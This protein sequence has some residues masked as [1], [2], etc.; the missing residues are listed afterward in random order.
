MVLQPKCWQEAWRNCWFS[1]RLRFNQMRREHQDRWLNPL[2]WNAPSPCTE[3]QCETTTNAHVALTTLYFRH[4]RL[5]TNSAIYSYKLHRLLNGAE[6][7]GFLIHQMNWSSMDAWTVDRSF[8]SLFAGGKQK[9][10][11][12]FILEMQSCQVGVIWWRRQR[13]VCAGCGKYDVG[14]A[15]YAC[16]GSLNTCSYMEIDCL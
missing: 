4:S 9:F 16:G 10:E 13:Y 14:R 1:A 8:W 7:H 11:L 3:H 15:L 6:L 12:S 2:W 5:T